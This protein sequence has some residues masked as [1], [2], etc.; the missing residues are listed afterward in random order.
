MSA[1]AALLSR[2]R[3]LGVEVIVDDGRLRV[4][5]ARGQL[6]PELKTAIS[7]QKTGLLALLANNSNGRSPDVTR[8]PRDGPLPLS[9]FQE[10]LWVQ[11]RF[12][13]DSTAYNM[14]AAWPSPGPIETSR[15]VEAIDAIVRRHEILRSC[16]RED[17]GVPFVSLLPPDAVPVEVRDLTGE[18]PEAQQATILAENKLATHTPFDLR[19]EPPVRFTVFRIAEG[20]VL[21]VVSAHHIAMDAWSFAML[22]R[23]IVAAYGEKPDE[24][25]PDALDYVDFAAW[26]RRTLDDRTLGREL[27]WWKKRLAGAPK[28]STLPHDNRG[29]P[30]GTGDAMEFRFSRD[31]SEGIR[32]LVRE[33]RATVYM[34]LLGACAILVNWHTGQEDIVLG[35]PMGLRER[36]EFETIVGPFVSLI[37]L[38]LD[39]SGD[40]T[41]AELLARTRSTVLDAHEHRLVPFEKVVEHVNPERSMEHAPL[42]Q[43][44][45][46]QHNAGAD[47]L[48]IASGGALFDL[49]WFVRES[50]GAFV[51]G[52]EYRSDR[53]SAE[54]IA[55]VAARLEAIL[56]RAVENRHLRMS[57]VARLSPSEERPA[58]GDLEGPQSGRHES[59]KTGPEGYF[60]RQLEGAPPLD[61]PTDRPRALRRPGAW[62]S[63]PIPL[64]AR[65]LDI[66]R[67]LAQQQETTLPAVLLA[68]F[69]VLLHRHTG[70][71]DITV[72]VPLDDGTPDGLAAS[73]APVRAVPIRVQ[74]N[75]E[76]DFAALVR[77]VRDATA[78][79]RGRPE[80]L[81]ELASALARAREVL[82]SP[83]PSVLFGFADRAAEAESESD[84]SLSVIEGEP[85]AIGS[86][87]YDSALF[88]AV[89]IRRFADHYRSI[90]E[91]VAADPA[92]RV[93]R[94]PLMSAQERAELL[95]RARDTCR[96]APPTTPVV[97]L[98]E[99]Q[100]RRTPDATAVIDGVTTLS[101]RALDVAAS[102]LAMRLQALGSKPGERVAVS[103]E[104]SASVVVALLAVL[105]TGA[106]YVPVDPHYPPERGGY[107]LDD[108]QPVVLIAENGIRD[109]MP[110]SAQVAIVSLDA[111]TFALEQTTPSATSIV[112][113]DSVAYVLYTSGSTGRPKGVEV[114]N[115]ALTNFLVSM[116]HR[117]G[118]G[119]DDHLLS[120]TTISFDIA[121]LEIFLPLVTGACVEIVPRE[122]TMDGVRLA[123]LIESSGAT[124]MQATPATWRMLIE[125]GWRGN[126]RLKILCGGEAMPRELANHLLARA[127]SVWNMY[128]PTETTVWSTVHRVAREEG[129]VSIGG[130]IDN[131]PVYILDAHGE[132]LPFG[133][134]GELFIGG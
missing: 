132:L 1:A 37:V 58:Y 67:D 100:A 130:P 128:G 47:S 15:V 27:D 103:L 129:P 64:P 13:P 125:A 114:P 79:F 3:S 84:L 111:R 21:T 42:F 133:V 39:L 49:T 89:S 61:L 8:V 122:L 116:Q 46:V 94:V 93:S 38:R 101:Y 44:G 45:V 34:A 76:T 12:Q 9:F 40:P 4:S 119:P 106:A 51:G 108:A 124:V 88:D 110:V 92:L 48:T 96:T 104:R 19:A 50:E 71:T 33:E 102:A 55:G 31:L 131:T 83:P 72:G 10:R 105:K 22:G 62:A 112:D 118:L 97:C 123:Q 86:V 36:P 17:G 82:Q 6:T 113:P 66:L 75:P 70:Q 90:L 2:L 5:A 57:E 98:F 115:R 28:T 56:A 81:A 121:G 107:V 24:T 120:V 73:P 69:E 87:G 80:P 63:V 95:A 11:S 127:G 126:A 52:V 30:D 117:P 43:V 59:S 26:Q 134:A 60:R 7:E 99:Q 16:F 74:V 25:T 85:E 54:T 53:Y 23:E 32:T 20:R 91:A 35:S 78:Q 18:P 65:A 29:S 109:R 68:A 41:F 14:L 77:A